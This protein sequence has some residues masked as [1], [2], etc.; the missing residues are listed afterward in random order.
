MP[1]Q[2]VGLHEATTVHC[3]SQ[4]LMAAN[5]AHLAADTSCNERTRQDIKIDQTNSS[6]RSNLSI[7]DGEVPSFTQTPGQGKRLRGLA[8]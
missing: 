4:L 8:G 1:A 6:K 5:N 3:D 7:A 2:A